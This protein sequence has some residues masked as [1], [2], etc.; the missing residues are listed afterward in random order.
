MSQPSKFDP[1]G[2]LPTRTNQQARKPLPH[3]LRHYVIAENGC[4]E[5]TGTRNKQ[6]YG[7]VGIAI[8][9]R[10]AG[11]LAPRVQWMHHHGEI[12]AGQVIRHT[13]DNPP[14]IN[15]DHLRCGTYQD[16]HDDMRSKG[17]QNYTGLKYSKGISL[18]ERYGITPPRLT[19]A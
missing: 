9:K 13:C 2:P 19:R 1:R 3:L 10:P 6:G 16:N 5:W 8:N 11:M 7:V 15:P 12:P 17:R 14:C 4:W 18:E